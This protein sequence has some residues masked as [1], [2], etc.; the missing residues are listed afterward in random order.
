MPDLA[1]RTILFSHFLRDRGFKIFSSSIVDS[2]RGLEQIDISI[3]D[4]FLAILRA[5][6]VTNEAE[7][8]LFSKLF[9]EFW[10]DLDL[11]KE[12]TRSQ[13]QNRHPEGREDSIPD[14]FLYALPAE[15]E[16]AGS[17]DEK[18]VFEGATYSPVELL[19]R[20]DL[21]DFERGDIQI[22]QLILKS[23]MSPFKIAVTRRFKR[24]KKPGDIDFRGVL[25]KGLKAEGIPFELLYRKKRKRLKKLLV[26]ADVSGSM[27]R[28]ARFVMP[29]IMGLKGVGPRAEIFVFSTSLTPITPTLRRY[30]TEK[31]LEIISRQVPDWSG[32]TRIG[33]SLH[34]FN[35]R[36]GL[37]LLNKRTVVVIMSDGWDLGAKELL[38]REMENLARKAYSIIWLNPLAGDPD[39][40]PLCKGMQTALP[41]VD[42]FLPANSLE[43]LKGVGRMLSRV[44]AGA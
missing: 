6:M 35:E 33:Y 27:D 29:F 22:A 44:M 38:R 34:Q 2:L 30:P 26:L 10:Q 41:Y 13:K 16:E 40:K 14:R 9:D 37:R 25:R 5:N 20:K 15:E 24:S 19:Q 21:A 3:R 4:D 17:R 8:K 31:A 7:W 12:K 18:R 32:G 39:Y 42:Y 1:K 28:Y 11:I 23:M 43:S 36:H